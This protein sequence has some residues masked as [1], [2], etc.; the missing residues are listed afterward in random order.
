MISPSKI[1]LSNY[2]RL[3]KLNS[4][5][6]AK[7]DLKPKIPNLNDRIANGGGDS[8]K[9]VISLIQFQIPN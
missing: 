2:I 6:P 3:N 8:T 7:I 5:I 9:K 1:S 4:T